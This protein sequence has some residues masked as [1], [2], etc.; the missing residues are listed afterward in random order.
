MYLEHF[1]LQRQPFSEHAGATSLWVDERMSEALARLEYFRDSGALALV[2]GP[3]G[4]GKS[5]LLR[6]F[7]HGLPQQRR[8]TGLAA[9]VPTHAVAQSG[10]RISRGRAGPVI[11]TLDGG[12]GKANGLAR[13]RVRPAAPGELLER[14][15]Q[16][17]ALARR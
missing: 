14:A 17:A 8:E 10:D 4:V 12:G 5:A 11:P 16:L 7:L 6:R 13:Q 3:N 2:T 15:A 1:K 9:D